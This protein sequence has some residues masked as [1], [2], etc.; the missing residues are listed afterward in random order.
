MSGNFQLRDPRQLLAVGLGAGLAPKA[1]GTW[2]TLAGLPLV[3]ALSDLSLLGYLTV[4]ALLF[5][6]GC[7]ICDITTRAASLHDHPAI[8]YDEVVGIL[9]TMAGLPA[10]LPA[11][12]SGFLLFRLLDIL[13][14]W[15]IRLLDRRITGGLGI[16]L[17]DVA[18]GI[19]AAIVLH[20]V[21]RFALPPPIAG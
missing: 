19:L 20:Y 2:G 18:A 17:D 1:P 14:P 6:L 16:M 12:M 5:A 11:L 7:Y 9:I 15:P 21:S 10:N 4:T 13:K 3:W 8:V